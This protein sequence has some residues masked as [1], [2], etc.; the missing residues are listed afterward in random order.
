[1][2]HRTP[3]LGRRTSRRCSCSVAFV[4]GSGHETRPRRCSCGTTRALVCVL[5]H[6]AGPYQRVR[7]RN[8]AAGSSFG[9]MGTPPSRFVRVARCVP[10]RDLVKRNAQRPGAFRRP[11]S[12]ASTRSRNRGCDRRRGGR[13]RLQRASVCRVWGLRPLGLDEVQAGARLDHEVELAAVVI[14]VEEHA[15]L[16]S[17]AAMERRRR[18]RGGTRAGRDR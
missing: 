16:G 5:R 14:P 10:L 11:G 1:M 12:R 13:R 7:F 18:V 6:H 3:R 4:R 15:R 9:A 2:K 17:R 8:R